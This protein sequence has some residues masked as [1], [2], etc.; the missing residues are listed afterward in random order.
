MACSSTTCGVT[1]QLVRL[2]FRAFAHYQGD[3]QLPVSRHCRVIPTA[4]RFIAL[5]LGTMFLFF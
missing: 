3:H 2:V 4:P 1:H 5:L